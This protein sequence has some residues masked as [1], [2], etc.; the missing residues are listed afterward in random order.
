MENVLLFGCLLLGFVSA[1]VAGVFLS[2]SDF[3]MAG[4]GR[5]APAG[6]IESM[7]HINRTVFRSVFLASFLTLVPAT[8][9]FA[10]LALSS[11]DG[12]GRGL[13]IAAALIYVTSVFGVTMFGNV[14]MNKRLDVVDFRSS[15]AA[16]YWRRYRQGWTYWNHVRTIGSAVTAALFMLA[17]VLIAGVA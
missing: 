12:P 13:V 8:T 2:F 10:V 14:P 15:D 16:D 6:G 7:Q 3:V 17:A 5:A 1:L 9:G 4:L 11:G